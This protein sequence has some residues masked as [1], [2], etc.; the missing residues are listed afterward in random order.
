MRVGS[1]GA[2][3]GQRTVALW[4]CVASRSAPSAA[5]KDIL[6]GYGYSWPSFLMNAGG[7]LFF[8]ANDGTHGDELWKSDGTEAG[9]V[10]VKD[11]NPTGSSMPTSFV[12]IAGVVFFIAEDGV[13][14]TGL[15]RTDGTPEGTT[16]VK[17]L[18]DASSLTKL[19]A[20]L[21][22]TAYDDVFGSELWTSDGTEAGTTMVKDINPE[23]GD[24]EPRAPCW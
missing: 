9:T 17:D 11:I 5:H 21:F 19:G 16:M 10:M 13:H 24:S 3:T 18:V 1:V 8:E 2:A 23:E 15:W 12:E 14:G 22:L 4:L 20:G 6:P 7:T